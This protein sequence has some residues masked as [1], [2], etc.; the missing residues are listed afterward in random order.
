MLEALTATATNGDGAT[1]EF[2]QCA[3]NAGVV[4]GYLTQEN[5]TVDGSRLSQGIFV[6]NA[7]F[8]NQSGS[9]LNHGFFNVTELAYQTGELA[10]AGWW[11][12]TQLADQRAKA[13]WWKYLLYW[14]LAQP[15]P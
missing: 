4:N 11:C 3:T 2:S 5:V 9:R 13:H 8:R 1:S 10:P 7:T 14:K 6:I 15:L 12:R